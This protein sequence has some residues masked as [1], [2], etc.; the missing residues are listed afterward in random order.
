MVTS[1][2]CQSVTLPE[3]H[4]DC[5]YYSTGWLVQSIKVPQTLISE[6]DTSGEAAAIEQQRRRKRTTRPPAA[7]AAKSRRPRLLSAGKNSSVERVRAVWSYRACVGIIACGDH[8]DL[9]SV[10]VVF[11]ARSRALGIG[12]GDFEFSR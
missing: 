6:S 7:A 11:H 1:R 12:G 8:C 2:S 3:P 4:P 9:R 10:A 5:K